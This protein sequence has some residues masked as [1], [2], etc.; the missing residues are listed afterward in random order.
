M[1]KRSL[2]DGDVRSSLAA[3]LAES[4]AHECARVL[5]ELKVPRPSARIDIALVNG[6]LTGYEIKSDVDSLSRLRSQIPA[7]ARVFDRAYLVTTGRHLRSSLKAIPF[8][9]G[10]AIACQDNRG[11]FIS[12]IRSSQ[13][14]T[15]WCVKSSLH[16][17][18][19]LELKNI[20][21][22]LCG[23]QL[24]LSAKREALVEH[25]AASCDPQAIRANI[26]EALRGR[27]DVA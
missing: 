17:L 6:E 9:W 10:I 22:A 18:T 4:H 12:Q 8:W 14:N 11:V 27:S 15:N 7:C 23:S 16:M 5:H 26:N 24:P 1:E 21:L 3:W 19:K 20:S 2:R 25:L 13:L